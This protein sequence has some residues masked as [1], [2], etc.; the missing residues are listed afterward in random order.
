ML[1][2]TVCKYT[3]KCTQPISVQ[4]GAFIVLHCTQK[5]AKN[6]HLYTALFLLPSP[7]YRKAHTTILICRQRYYS[8]VITF[9]SVHC[10]EQYKH[11]IV[12]STYNVH[13]C[14]QSNANTV[15]NN[16]KHTLV[17]SAYNVHCCRL[18]NANYCKY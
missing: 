4:D 13:C 18:S 1:S 11:T 9:I 5:N 6:P 15:V 17:N 16:I 7:V 10:C 2:C 8:T 12:N 3:A 14:R